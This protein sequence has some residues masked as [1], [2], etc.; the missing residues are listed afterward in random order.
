MVTCKE[1]ISFDD[2]DGCCNPNC[3]HVWDAIGPDDPACV[4]FR[5]EEDEDKDD[6]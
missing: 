6:A 4:F 5:G 1:C 3:P 2:Y